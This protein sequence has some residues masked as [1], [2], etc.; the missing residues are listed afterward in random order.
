MLPCLSKTETSRMYTDAVGQVPG[1]VAWEEKKGEAYGG[2]ADGAAAKARARLRE[3]QR[4]LRKQVQYAG[5]LSMAELMSA[6]QGHVDDTGSSEAASAGSEGADGPSLSIGAAPG[7]SG[8]AAPRLPPQVQVALNGVLTEDSVGEAGT[9]STRETIALPLRRDG[10]DTVEMVLHAVKVVRGAVQSA[11]TVGLN[12][13][14][15]SAH[16][17]VK[18]LT[19]N[20]AHLLAAGASADSCMEGGWS[21]LMVLCWAGHAGHPLPLAALLSSG[22]TAR[23]PLERSINPMNLQNTFHMMF[24]AATGYVGSEPGLDGALAPSIALLL[25]YGGADACL[26][27]DAHG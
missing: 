26:A 1:H 12:E 27:R 4:E 13:P 11:V 5:G 2:I 21:P 18:D 24:Q 9:T 6:A 25:Q 15:N 16:S 14:R 7:A 19:W 8:V 3:Q 22:C 20:I 10:R 23:V 17:R